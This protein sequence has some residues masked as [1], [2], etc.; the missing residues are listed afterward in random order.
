MQITYCN[1]FHQSGFGVTGNLVVIRYW[2]DSVAH[3]RRLPL[4]GFGRMTC[5]D[6]LATAKKWLRKF[7]PDAEIV[8]G[9]PVLVAKLLKEGLSDD[10]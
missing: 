2:E 4:E 9:I 8:L 7:H 5:F 10:N 3:S 6:Y 1:E